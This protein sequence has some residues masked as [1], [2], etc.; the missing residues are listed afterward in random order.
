VGWGEGTT[1]EM[2]VG[3]VGIILD[4]EALSNLFLQS[5]HRQVKRST[6]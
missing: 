2:V 4:Q 5:V 3:Y 1:D 6:H